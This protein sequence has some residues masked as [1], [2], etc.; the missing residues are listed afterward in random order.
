MFQ[1]F[2]FCFLLLTH[3]HCSKV[4]SSWIEIKSVQCLSATCHGISLVTLFSPR[5]C[6]DAVLQSE[7]GNHEGYFGQFSPLSRFC[8]NLWWEFRRLLRLWPYLHCLSGKPHLVWSSQATHQTVCESRRWSCMAGF[9]PGYLWL[10]HFLLQPLHLAP[11]LEQASYFSC[12]PLHSA[13]ITS[14]Q[15]M[16]ASHLLCLHHWA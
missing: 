13:M 12:F 7:T 4:C 10:G 15:R 2:C 16:A 3:F 14:G 5:C 11:S 9:D 1:A 8:W 6:Y